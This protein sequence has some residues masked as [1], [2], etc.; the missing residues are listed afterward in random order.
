MPT[1]T[2]ATLLHISL[3]RQIHLI[4]IE[5]LQKQFKD[6]EEFL[7]W[8]SDEKKKSKSQY[9]LQCAPKISLDAKI[10][11]YYCHRAGK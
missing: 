11:Y 7:I 6:F 9:T 3:I 10:W 2:G 4:K 1:I 5:V 8:K